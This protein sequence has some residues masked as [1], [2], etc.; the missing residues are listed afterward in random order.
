MHISP[1]VSQWNVFLLIV[2][3]VLVLQPLYSFNFPHLHTVN[4]ITV[5][6]FGFASI[7]YAS[8]CKFSE[9]NFSNECL[10]SKS[11]KRIKSACKNI[12]LKKVVTVK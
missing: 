9:E 2:H 8:T 10:E 7:Y 1:S 5:N 12:F 3:A 11:K 4:I 6:T